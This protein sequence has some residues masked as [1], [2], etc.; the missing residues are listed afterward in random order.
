[1]KLLPI[2]LIIISLPVYADEDCVFNESTYVEFINKYTAANSSARIE[3]D[4]RTLIVNSDNEKIIVKGGGCIHLGASIALKTQQAY[5]EEQF[6][7][8]IEDEY[9]LF[10]SDMLKLGKVTEKQLDSYQRNLFPTQG[11]KRGGTR[12]PEPLVKASKRFR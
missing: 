10:F 11:K 4:G 3:P 1:M 12:M 2:L 7:K 8:K 5:T 9:A 6:L